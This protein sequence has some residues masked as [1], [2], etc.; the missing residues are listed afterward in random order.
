MKEL[1]RE[2]YLP[3]SISP[4]Q[5]DFILL[6]KQLNFS[7]KIKL[8]RLFPNFDIELSDAIYGELMGNL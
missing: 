6:E 1:I 7:F 8:I 3:I 5:D 4:V 2:S